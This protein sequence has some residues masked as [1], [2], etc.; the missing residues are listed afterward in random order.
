MI[1][2]SVP[3]NTTATQPVTLTVEE[4]QILTKAVRYYKRV[5]LLS[6]GKIG[7]IEKVIVC[8]FTGPERWT[9]KP[10]QPMPEGLNWDQWCNQTELRPYHALLHRGWARW[11]D[12]DGGGQSWGVSGWGTHALDQVQDALGTSLTGPLEMIPDEPGPKG[13]VSRPTLPRKVRAR[14][15]SPPRTSSNA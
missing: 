11:W 9:A 5:Q 1:P 3:I 13:K 12:Y 7:K 15:S 14:C 8:N 10:E 6:S 2:S 4:G